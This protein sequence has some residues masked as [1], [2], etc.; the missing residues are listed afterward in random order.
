MS[1]PSL[2]GE[3]WAAHMRHRPTPSDREAAKH[4]LQRIRMERELAKAGDPGAIEL[5]ER[6]GWA[7]NGDIT[8]RER[9]LECVA[10][11]DCELHVR[12]GGAKR[13]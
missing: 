1:Q 2:D 9:I 12:A 4:I 6:F 5:L 3:A 13:Q 7:L 10:E 11:K 8:D